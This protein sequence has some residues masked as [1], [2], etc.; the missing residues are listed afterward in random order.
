MK[1]LI[2]SFATLF[3]LHG[4]AAIEYGCHPL[5]PP[6]FVEAAI[7]HT[8]GTL[9]YYTTSETWGAVDEHIVT[10][11]DRT[12][13]NN[14]LTVSSRDLTLTIDRNEELMPGEF[15]SRFQKG[16]LDVEMYCLDGI[17]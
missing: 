3:S 10:V 9:A 17:F 5:N 12:D 14:V 4:I 16:E 6:E 8:D 13:R 15:I 11:E 1:T 2:L 7:L